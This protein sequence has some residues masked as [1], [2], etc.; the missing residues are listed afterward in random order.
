LLRSVDML[1]M[2]E[3]VRTPRAHGIAAVRAAERPHSFER[4]R[5]GASALRE[6]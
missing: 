3:S 1:R 5:R 6:T 2:R 4:V